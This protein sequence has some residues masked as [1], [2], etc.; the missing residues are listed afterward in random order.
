MAAR[1]IAGENRVDVGAGELRVGWQRIV[2]VARERPRLEANALG[3]ALFA[4]V[5][6]PRPRRDGDADL[7][8]PRRKA[9]LT[10][11]EKGNR[12][13]IAFREL[14]DAHRIGAGFQDFFLAEG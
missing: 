7:V 2:M 6:A 1:L 9:H 5:R 10:L 14:I 3:R 12:T 8:A 4:Q 11:A 13:Q